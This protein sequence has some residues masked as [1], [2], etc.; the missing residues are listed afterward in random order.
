MNPA[1]FKNGGKTLTISHGFSETL[2]G[3]V[4][5]ASIAKGIC[6]IDFC[7]IKEI[8]FIDLKTHF[9]NATFIHSRNM[10]QVQ[11]LKIFD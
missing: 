1:E 7:E 6:F 3:N 2:F 5:I 10:Y 4:L 8:A 9:P 11:A